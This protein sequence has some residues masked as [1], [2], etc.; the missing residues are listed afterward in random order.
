[1]FPTSYE[2][3]EELN[4]ESSEQSMGKVFLFDF[5]EKRHVLKD[6]KPVLATYEQAITQ[7]LTMLII[8]EV[9]KY[10]VYKESGFGL[11]LYRFIGRKDIPVGVI[12]SEV[13]RQIEEKALEHPEIEALE[14]FEI[15]RD[16]SR[17]TISFTV[18]TKQ[19]VI[20]A[21][22]SEAKYNGGNS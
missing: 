22:K 3:E 20:E 19:G 12:L 6:G 5:N 4:T 21:F 9:D 7:W 18:I 11:E 1:M 16:G 15:E 8:T 17:A 2:V 13:S 10:K 14:D